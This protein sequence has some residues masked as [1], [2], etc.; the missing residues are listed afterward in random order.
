MKELPV[1]GIACIQDLAQLAGLQEA[2]EILANPFAA[3]F[4][5]FDWFY[6]C[7]KA[8]VFPNVLSIQVL[9]RNDEV[10]AIAPL[11]RVK[12]KFCYRYELLG[13]H[14]LGEPSG[15]LYR[16]EQALCTL[17]KKLS[18]LNN[19]IRLRRLG[20]DSLELQLLSE[21]F[22]GSPL[23][24]VRNGGKSPT[25]PIE[26]TWEQYESGMSSRR[27]SDLRRARRR[28]KKNGEVS[29]RIFSPASDQAPA[30]LQE[31]M[32]VEH[33]SWKGENQSSLLS[34]PVLAR[35]FSEYTL[36]S[37]QKGVLRMAFLYVDR[38]PVAGLLGVEEFNRFW[39]L[40]IGYDQR[41]ANCSPGILVMHEVIKYAFE[42]G[43]ERF[44]FCGWDAPWMHMWTKETRAYLSPLIYS[45]SLPGMMVLMKDLS[46][47]IAKKFP[48]QEYLRLKSTGK[49]N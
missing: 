30:L 9:W 15:I 41:Y 32:E 24:S 1:N 17:L 44:E 4:L 48:V 13:S 37:A 23:F 3:P 18:E 45:L 19:P 22:R 12:E 26:S 40:K 11:E 20:A 47:Y 27:L 28:L 33:R 29:F 43:L 38:K 5:G 34:R 14:F 2:W 7:A 31:F 39:V 35:F 21:L 16:D 6:S 49:G 10:A 25:L 42:Q 8:V 36:R 46:G